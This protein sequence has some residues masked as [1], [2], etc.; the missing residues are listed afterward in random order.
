MA[1]PNIHLYQQYITKFLNTA[2]I[3]SENSKNESNFKYELGMQLQS[4]L[5]ILNNIEQR[6]KIALINMTR[7][8]GIDYLQQF[9]KPTQANS[10]S[11][12][13]IQDN[14]SIDDYND[15]DN[16]YNNENINDNNT[17][18]NT[19]NGDININSETNINN[20]DSDSD[21]FSNGNMIEN[22]QNNIKT[23]TSMKNI[24][25][26]ENIV[27]KIERCLPQNTNSSEESSSEEEDNSSDDNDDNDDNN[28]NDDSSDDNDENDNSLND[29]EDSSDDN[30]NSSDENDDET[31]QQEV[32]T[33]KK[34]ENIDND[35]SLIL[36]PSICLAKLKNG[37]NCIRKTQIGTNYCGIH[38]RSIKNELNKSS[39]KSS[40]S[41]NNSAKNMDNDTDTDSELDSENE[42]TLVRRIYKKKTYLIS[43]DKSEV[44]DIE[45]RK[46]VGKFINNK[47]ILDN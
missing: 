11:G 9:K 16:E 24:S 44:Y 32:Q 40:I 29:N 1:T 23:I 35:K 42:L 45:T 7:Y 46:L 38:N 8:G 31:E 33:E 47:I 13:S 28:N 3:I 39:P 43:I 27:N 12:D 21:S 26:M 20:N 6:Y 18:N 2:W 30:D 17:G 15:I 19:D 14:S 37:T 34:L 36:S 22:I 41:V 25:S 10:V 5:N 4:L